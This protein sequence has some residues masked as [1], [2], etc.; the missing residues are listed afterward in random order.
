MDE[1]MVVKSML[2][3]YKD[4]DKIN[5]QKSG[6][7]FI[8]NIRRDKQQELSDILRVHN[9]LGDGKYLGLQSLIGRSKKSVF[10]F[11]KE[12]VCKRIQ[13]Q[14]NKLFS[15]GGKA[16]LIESVTQSVSSYCMS[17]FKILKSLC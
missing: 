3:S 11:L 17:Y 8:T 2:N 12:R 14:D 16:V 6:I 13:G 9:D 5:F 15:R 7:F 10:N 4:L 1:T